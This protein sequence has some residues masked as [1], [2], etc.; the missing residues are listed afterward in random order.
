MCIA[1]ASY[2]GYSALMGTLQHPELYRCAVA[3]VAVSDPLLLFQWNWRSD[4]SDEARLYS[5]P[6][7]IGDPEADAARLKEVSPLTQAARIKTPLLLAYGQ[8]DR[9]VPIYH[10]TRLREALQAAGQ[11][12]EWVA[13]I[14][15][16]H[17][18]RKFENKIDFA[19]R[20]E[21]FLGKHLAQ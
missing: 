19:K 11:E 14:G 12:P 10:G 18:W 3:W 2:G 16:G 8:D 21:A 15:E 9:R 1:G 5:L 20:F 13:Y 17:G 7:M 6:V 4:M